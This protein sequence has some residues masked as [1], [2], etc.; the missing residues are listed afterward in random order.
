VL[1]HG[2]FSKGNFTNR[3]SSKECNVRSII[4]DEGANLFFILWLWANQVGAGLIS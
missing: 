1:A 4:D 2:R 3:F